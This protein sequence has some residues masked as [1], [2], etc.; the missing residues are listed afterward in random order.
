MNQKQTL[1]LDELLSHTYDR[2][3]ELAQK[4][5]HEKDR[6]N[7]KAVAESVHEAQAKDDLFRSPLGLPKA[8]LSYSI[9]T[10][11][12]QYDFYFAHL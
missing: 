4:I 3:S 2:I 10:T 1:P 8:L 11:S 9:L 5:L 6:K 12:K 7:A